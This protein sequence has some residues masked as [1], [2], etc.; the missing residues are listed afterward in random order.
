MA[1]R[2]GS[3]RKVSNLTE[4]P[5]FPSAKQHLN[6]QSQNIMSTGSGLDKKPFTCRSHLCVSNYCKFQVPGNLLTSIYAASWLVR[7]L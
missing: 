5:T 1:T 7:D 2:V 4:P 6:L 3:R